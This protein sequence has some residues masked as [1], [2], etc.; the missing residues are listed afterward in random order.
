M[1]MVFWNKMSEEGFVQSKEKK[2]NFGID[3][4]EIYNYFIL[5]LHCE[6]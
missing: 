5:H 6:N 3:L 4:G 1:E 2:N